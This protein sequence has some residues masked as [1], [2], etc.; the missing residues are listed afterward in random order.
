MNF[1]LWTC[2]LL[3]VSLHTIFYGVLYTQRTFA[4]AVVI[5][6]VGVALTTHTARTSLA[7][8]TLPILPTPRANL[9]LVAAL[10]LVCH[11]GG[12]W[13]GLDYLALFHVYY[14]RRAG[15]VFIKVTNEQP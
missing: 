5:G 6:L 2:T 10:L 8:H 7:L 14:T 4:Y 12:G 3:F 11:G 1:L 13:E 15:F 9:C